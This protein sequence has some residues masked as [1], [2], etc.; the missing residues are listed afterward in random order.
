MPVIQRVQRTVNIPLVQYIDTQEWWLRP[1]GETQVTVEYVP[2]EVVRLIPQER[3]AAHSGA[4]CPRPRTTGRGR[5]GGRGPD[6]SQGRI[7]KRIIDR[8]LDVPV[9]KQRQALPIQ[10]V[11]KTLKVPQTSVAGPAAQPQFIDKVVDDSVLIQRQVPSPS[12]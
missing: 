3:T 8:I 2:K 10:T 6:H 12:V 7:S 9:V 5:T 4:D 1:D 11:Q